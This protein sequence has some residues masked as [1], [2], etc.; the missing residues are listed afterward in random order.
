MKVVHFFIF[1]GVLGLI[2]GL[3][4]NELSSEDRAYLLDQ[5]GEVQE[6]ASKL[7]DKEFVDEGW[8][9]D[10]ESENAVQVSVRE[11]SNEG[12]LGRVSFFV[13][14]MAS[15]GSLDVAALDEGTL[16]YLEGYADLQDGGEG[17]FWLDKSS[18]ELQ[19]DGGVVIA[20]PQEDVFWRRSYSEG[21]VDVRWFGATGEGYPT[22]D[23]PAILK[24]IS[25]YRYLLFPE[26]EYYVSSPIP[27]S[28]AQKFEGLGNRSSPEVRGVLIVGETNCFEAEQL[29]SNRDVS[30]LNLA[31]S[32]RSP[33][34][35]GI[36]LDEE[37]TSGWTGNPIIQ[38][39]IFY[40]NLKYGVRGTVQ[41]G[42]IL[43]SGFGT[44]GS[45]TAME[46]GIY[47]DALTINTS[48][49][50]LESRFH[51]AKAAIVLE[52]TNGVKITGCEF[53]MLRGVAVWLKGASSVTISDSYFERCQTSPGDYDGFIRLDTSDS[54]VGCRGT[55]ILGNYFLNN[56]DKNVSTFIDG[57]WVTGMTAIANF[58][59]P[60]REGVSIYNMGARRPMFAAGNILISNVFMPKDD[61]NTYDLLKQ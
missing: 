39:C 60:M 52:D 10:L 6:D 42:T 1:A 7:G 59:G 13:S 23:Y 31:F 33:E 54:G 46:V 51:Y 55:L 2:H 30:W 3:S 12:N 58:Y 34:G 61:I 48:L 47:F 21:G 53:E 56:G 24:A 50:I 29:G 36:L 9:A 20:T 22:D 16:V 40:A 15:L 28:S 25:N 27:F 14:T 18:P 44:K 49:R 38:S 19:A 45:V 35:I 57:Q 11:V 32:T 8:S 41:G 4:A 43:N 5:L 37:K 17:I 26:G